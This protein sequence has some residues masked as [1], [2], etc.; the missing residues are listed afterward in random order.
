M[1]KIEN[2]HHASLPAGTVLRLSREITDQGS[3]TILYL[4]SESVNHGLS[5]PVPRN[6]FFTPKMTVVCT[7]FTV[8]ADFGEIPRVQLV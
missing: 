4:Q 2:P 5:T 1:E 3:K 7:G 8:R 6:P